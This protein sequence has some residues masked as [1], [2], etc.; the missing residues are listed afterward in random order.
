MPN[1]L[2]PA[3]A[4]TQS[5]QALRVSEAERFDKK[6]P[7]MAVKDTGVE[8]HYI[9]SM[10]FASMHRKDGIKIGFLHGHFSSRME[11]DQKYLDEEI[12]NGHPNIRHA[13]DEESRNAL[14]MKDPIGTLRKE[15]TAQVVGDAEKK[16]ENL[17]ARLIAEIEAA[18][19]V[20]PSSIMSKKVVES[21]SVIGNTASTTNLPGD[22][23]GKTAAELL[24]ERIQSGSGSLK[25]VS[26]GDSPGTNPN[27]LTPVS[28]KDIAQ[29]A[30]G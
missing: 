7:P 22:S 15:I 21:A 26:N 1:D 6:F 3:G 24:K 11:A 12:A 23:T 4:D 25:I 27:K 30:D 14:M 8:K 19:G 2:I 10:P 17:R 18:G 16:E 28:T 29:G 9:C 13:T 20:I 5:P